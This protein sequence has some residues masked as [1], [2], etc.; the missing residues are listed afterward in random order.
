[1]LKISPD[2]RFTLA[3]GNGVEPATAIGEGADAGQHDMRRA[4]DCLGIGCN[5]DLWRETRLARCALEGFPGRMQIAG[6]VIDDRHA[7]RCAPGSGKRPTMPDVAALAGAGGCEGGEGG[8]RFD[9][10]PL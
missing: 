9:A 4:A 5:A 3:A 6:P 7:H 10:A 8:D 2:E 1:M